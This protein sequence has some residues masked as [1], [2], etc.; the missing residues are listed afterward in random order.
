MNTLKNIYEQKINEWSGGAEYKT[1]ARHP[2]DGE[3]A[4][5]NNVGE[6]AW[7]YLG[8]ITDGDFSMWHGNLDDRTR[9]K[10]LTDEERETAKVG[11]K[12]MAE[13]RADLQ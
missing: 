10:T 1:W 11:T 12:L 5:L 7:Y 3:T 6:W 9:D 8:Y 2:N 4:D 13:Y